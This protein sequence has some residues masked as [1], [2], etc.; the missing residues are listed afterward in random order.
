MLAYKSF[1]LFC[2]TNST[3]IC[4]SH[5]RCFSPPALASGWV[6]LDPPRNSATVEATFACIPLR[7][8]LVQVF[9]NGIWASANCLLC[10]DNILPE[11]VE[12]P[13]RSRLLR[14]IVIFR[15]WCSSRRGSC[16]WRG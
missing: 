3:T 12:L 6:V 11:P 5:E 2:S 1:G 16:R 8:F 15:C 9:R 14:F 10:L 13:V 4:D 7:V